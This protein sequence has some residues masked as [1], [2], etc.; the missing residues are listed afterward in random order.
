[1]RGTAVLPQLIL[2]RP[3]IVPDQEVQT[4]AMEHPIQDPNATP[5][6][7]PPQHARLSFLL[8]RL[9]EEEHERRV[10]A[11]PLAASLLRACAGS[12]QALER[13]QVT[14]H[15]ALRCAKASNGNHNTRQRGSLT[16]TSSVAAKRPE[17]N[18]LGD[19]NA[20]G[21]FDRNN[22]DPNVVSR[23]PN[24]KVDKAVYLPGG[25]QQEGRRI[26]CAKQRGF[27][28]KENG[29]CDMVDQRLRSKADRRRE[30][31]LSSVCEATKRVYAVLC[32]L[33]CGGVLGGVRLTGGFQL[34]VWAGKSAIIPL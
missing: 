1:M 11:G 26:G 27:L 2:Q 28:E 9:Q 33:C 18:L 19:K 22:K 5:D 8:K 31:L 15:D 7:S 20:T 34:T 29:L 3:Q 24:L 10:S 16:T 4:L 17:N 13:A 23:F 12:G 30:D 6:P 14:A 32:S 21:V 25:E